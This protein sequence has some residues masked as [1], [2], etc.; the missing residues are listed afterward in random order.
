MI[1]ARAST[2][3]AQCPALTHLLPS[4][5]LVVL[6]R[7]RNF[8]GQ[9]SGLTE[10]GLYL[11]A[12]RRNLVRRHRD[13]FLAAA[14]GVRNKT[15][16]PGLMDRRVKHKATYMAPVTWRLAQL[17]FDRLAAD[18]NLNNHVDAAGQIHANGDSVC[19]YDA[20]SWER[21][22]C[23]ANTKIFAADGGKFALAGLSKIVIEANICKMR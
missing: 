4:R 18:G 13:D 20:F 1:A 23:A 14:G 7:M 22:G 16:L 15:I 8:G 12:N 2:S 9:Y 21:C 11:P 5:S 17:S 3:P 19:A 10:A 6:I